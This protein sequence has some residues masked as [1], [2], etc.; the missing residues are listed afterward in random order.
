[1]KHLPNSGRPS[2]AGSREVHVSTQDLRNLKLV[3]TLEMPLADGGARLRL[4]LFAL[5][6]NNI[7]YA[8]TGNGFAGYWDFFPCI[9]GW[10][11][12]P[13]WGFGTV[14]ASKLAELEQGS[15]H[16]GFF[17]MAEMVDVLPVK[18]GAHGFVDG[19]SHRASKAAAYNWYA[20]TRSDPAYDPE[21]EA[22][23]VLLRPLY[24][25]G[26]WAADRVRRGSPRTV[27]ISSASSKTALAMAHKLRSSGESELIGL[28]STRH[29]DYVRSTGLYARVLTYD[30]AGTLG[31]APSSTYVDFLGNESLNAAVNRAL[32]ATLADSILIGATDW[33]AKPGGVRATAV[34]YGPVPE[35]LF[36][37]FYAPERM[38][39]DR[40]LGASML[41]DMREFYEASRAFVAPRR[42]SGEQ[43]ILDCWTHLAAGD[44][45]PQEGFVLSF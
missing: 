10:G 16:Y 25:S 34:E 18:A 22:E 5:T 38:K 29:V 43:A 33:A 15:R 19:A 30:E 35:I 41:R 13:V 23:Q 36:V 9:D 6:S 11:R 31:C 17:P 24:A 26:W 28:T 21:R 44:A 3:C 40:E 45:R 12:P 27:V 7:T 8:A 20:D 32:G 42:L 4:D 2:S 37:P 14:V 39:V 1:M